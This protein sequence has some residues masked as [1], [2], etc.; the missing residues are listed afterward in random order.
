MREAG[1]PPGP[2]AGSLLVSR[3]GLADPNFARSVVLLVEAG[4]QGAWGLILNRPTD[5]ELGGV[6]PDVEAFRGRPGVLHFG[7]PVEPRRVLA[8]VRTRAEPDESRAVL[9]GV[10]L[11][12]SMDVIGRLA[13]E[14]AAYRVFAG[15]AGWGAGQ[16]DAEL[17][18]GD[19][20]VMAADEALVFDHDGAG[21]WELLNRRSSTLVVETGAGRAPAGSGPSPRA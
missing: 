18:R 17:A 15:Y 5:L 21:L 1:L 9:E 20:H 14:G 2:A 12:W 7:G 8:L 4:D 19:W 11:C 16:L 3:E 10:R 13:R 6:F